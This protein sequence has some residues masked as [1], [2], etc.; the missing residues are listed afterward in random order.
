[1]PIADFGGLFLR[2]GI[3]SPVGG[4]SEDRGRTLW[5]S[6]GT[7]MAKRRANLHFRIPPYVSPRNRWRKLIYDAALAAMQEGQVTYQ[8]ED[9]LELE[10]VLYF[11]RATI[12]FHDV[13]N[14]LKDVLDALQARMG[15]PKAVRQHQPLIPND[16]QFFR[17]SVVKML[18]PKQ[19]HGRGH[20]TITRHR[21]H[22]RAAVPK[23]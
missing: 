17:V 9:R 12:G 5:S 19:S 22:D 10:L 20:V 15:G 14:R 21:D 4:S 11:D 1:M 8:A 13:D 6:T 2:T 7:A 16:N 18:P 3:L 23:R